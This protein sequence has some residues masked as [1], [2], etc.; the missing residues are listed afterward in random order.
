MAS[1]A[2]FMASCESF[3]VAPCLRENQNGR[4]S[5]CT[6]MQTGL[7]FEIRVTSLH[8]VTMADLS[9]VRGRRDDCAAEDFAGSSLRRQARMA[10]ISINRRNECRCLIPTPFGMESWFSLLNVARSIE[11]LD[12][13]LSDLI[14]CFCSTTG[15]Q[16]IARSNSTQ[17]RKGAKARGLWLNS[18]RLCGS[19]SL[20]LS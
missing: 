14:A 19:A 17:S 5:G 10:S 15:S 11:L 6:G 13:F 9:D 16:N 4:T 20:R 8:P 18:L 12:R 3:S 1:R 2:S 7:L